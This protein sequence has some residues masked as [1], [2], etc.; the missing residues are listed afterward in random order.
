MKMASL[1][2]ICILCKA[3]CEVIFDDKSCRV[4][5]KGKTILRGSKDPKSDLWTLPI[6]LLGGQWTTLG[7]TAMAS[8]AEASPSRPGLCKGPAP[9]TPLINP[10]VANFSYHRATKANVVKFMHQRLCNP[11][12]SSLIKA[13]NASFLQG[14]PHLTAFTVQKY[15][16]PSPATLKVKGRMKRPCKGIRSTT[17]KCSKQTITSPNLPYPIPAAP[18]IHTD[19]MPGLIPNNDGDSSG[20][21]PAFIEKI[22]DKSIASVFCFG[23]FANKNT[24]VIYNVYTGLSPSCCLVTMF[25]SL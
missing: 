18:S 20:P 7:P 15:L 16:M 8:T 9:L 10:E 21:C 24:A 3:G 12:I 23:A 13:F 19:A 14:T 22:D 5:F 6:F 11:L 1:L 2:G 17:P 4:N 25:V